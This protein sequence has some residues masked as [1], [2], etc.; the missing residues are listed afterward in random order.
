[1]VLWRKGR[2]DASLSPDDLRITD[3]RYG[4]IWNL[5]TC[6]TCEFIFAWPINNSRL[7][8]AYMDMTDEQYEE[9]EE[10]RSMQQR[11]LLNKLIRVLGR[12]PANLLDIGCGTGH[13]LSMARQ[14]GIQG[15]GVE[16]SRWA[17]SKARDKGLDVYQG[18]FPHPD[19]STR[20]FDAI[21][22]IDVLEHLSQPREFL[23]AVARQLAPEGITQIV[24]PDVGSLPAK[25]MGRRWWHF[26]LAHVCYFNMGS[27]T[28]MAEACGLS[29]VA[30][31][32]AWW[33]FS[34]RYLVER[35]SSYF[36]PMRFLLRGREGGIRGRLLSSVL[37]INLFDSYVFYLK[38]IDS[39]KAGRR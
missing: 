9:G 19:L 15:V 38:K 34:A 28:R 32:R 4:E 36:V 2:D 17:V 6:R 20:I 23:A 26:R 13:L 18:S 1:M 22:V 25:L 39:K 35:A 11:K 5:W 29:I 8:S 16:P 14:M 7:I 30:Y 31:H 21:T 33:Y 27:F 10:Y 12:K 37:P 24:T 3:D